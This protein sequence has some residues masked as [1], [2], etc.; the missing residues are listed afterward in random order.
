VKWRAVGFLTVVLVLA[1]GWAGYRVW[2]DNFRYR[3]IRRGNSP[4]P[5]LV[6]KQPI[7]KGMSGSLV[8][9][10]SM[11][12]ATTLPP[13]DVEVG[14][15]PDPSYLRDR[16]SVVDIFPGQQLTETNFPASAVGGG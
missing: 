8:V 15:I 6:A 5:M 12:T 10:Q 1:V 4:T 13:K 7:P 3:T 9:R 14:A 11:Y 2:D 16:V